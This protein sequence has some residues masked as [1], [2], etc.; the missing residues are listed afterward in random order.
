[1]LAGRIADRL[2]GRKVW[3]RGT[4]GRVATRDLHERVRAKFNGRNYAEVA[5][6][7]DIS[8]RQ[9]RRIVK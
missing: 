1:M 2:G 5:A 6:D 3:L 8:I 4:R 9:V 7:E